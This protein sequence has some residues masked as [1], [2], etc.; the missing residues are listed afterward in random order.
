MSSS[1]F[2]I[3][4]VDI[5]T[6]QT[7]TNFK[8]KIIDITWNTSAVFRVISLDS[9]NNVVKNDTVVVEGNSYQGWLNDDNYITHYIANELGYNLT[10]N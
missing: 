6:T 5:V 7:I 4:P 2:S 3:T 8:I 1:T 9:S 10:E